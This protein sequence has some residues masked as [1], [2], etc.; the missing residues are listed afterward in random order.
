MFSATL[1]HSRLSYFDYT[2]G[3]Q[4]TDFKRYLVHFFENIGGTTKEVLNDNM[5]AIVNINGDNCIIHPSICHFFKDIGVTL[6]L[7]RVRPYQTKGK[8][9]TSNKNMLNGY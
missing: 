1:E 2:E 9:E 5:S 7:C 3:K 4:E 6:K 8:Y